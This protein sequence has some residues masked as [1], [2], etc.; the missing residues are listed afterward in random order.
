MSG[1]NITIKGYM[2]ILV[3]NIFPVTKSGKQDLTLKV[4]PEINTQADYICDRII[5]DM[6]NTCSQDG[7]DNLFRIMNLTGSWCIVAGVGSVELWNNHFEEIEEKG[8]YEALTES[9]G[10][11]CMDEYVFDLI[12]IGNSGDVF[13]KERDLYL[14]VARETLLQIM[15]NVS[16]RNLE[17]F[18]KQLH[19]CMKALFYFGVDHRMN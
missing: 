14:K 18:Q 4:I 12:G 8:L 3:D 6:F 2:D 7:I 15:P 17:D 11:D 1:N 19:E 13:K 10:F 5:Q 9:K 16:P